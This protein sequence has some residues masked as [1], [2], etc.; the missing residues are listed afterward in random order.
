MSK[1][2][3]FNLNDAGSPEDVKESLGMAASLFMSY[4]LELSKLGYSKDDIFKI[5]E[6]TI[7]ISI[8]RTIGSFYT[9]VPLMV[10]MTDMMSDHSADG[11]ISA[12]RK[13][14]ELGKDEENKRN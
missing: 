8:D 1:V 12:Y 5:V 9:T 2:F 13:I 6:G 7:K 11:F 3:D 14:E 10:I 4:A